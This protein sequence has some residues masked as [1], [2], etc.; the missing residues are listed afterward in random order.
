VLWHRLLAHELIARGYRVV[1]VTLP[2][3]CSTWLRKRLGR[4]V[5]LH[6][7]V[8]PELAVEGV[9]D[10]AVCTLTASTTSR[11]RNCGWR[12]ARLRSAFGAAGG[13]S[14]IFTPH[15]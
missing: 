14:S 13:S 5:V 7:T 2:R 3:R 4:E 8:L 9:F 15:G 11:R 10:A 6:R 1:G 12:S